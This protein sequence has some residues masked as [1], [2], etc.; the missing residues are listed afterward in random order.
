MVKVTFI[1]QDG[2]RREIDAKEGEP[3]MYAA[4]GA[5]IAAIVAEC[6]G[7]A[8]CGTCH[9]YLIEAPN[10]PLPEPESAEADTL[11]FMANEPRDHS[12]LTCQITVTEALDGAV[13]EVATGR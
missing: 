4:K 9:C 11:E 12:R 10:G 3:L 2:T 1:E 6:G 8:I 7:A 13:F 5:G